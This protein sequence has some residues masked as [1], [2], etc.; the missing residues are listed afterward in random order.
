MAIHGLWAED[1]SDGKRRV[2]YAY[3]GLTAVIGVL[4]LYSA[5]VQSAH[6]RRAEAEQVQRDASNKGINDKLSQ[7]R[8]LLIPSGTKEDALQ[9]VLDDLVKGQEPRSI[10]RQ[11]SSVMS[12]ELSELPS[13]RVN[14]AVS[15]QANE[16]SEYA[17]Q[18]LSIFSSAGWNSTGVDT[19]IFPQPPTGISLMIKDKL[20][21]PPC[22]YSVVKA[23]SEN[24]IAKKPIQVLIDNGV[25]AGGL[26]ILVG[27][28]PAALLP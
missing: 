5:A 26:T 8:N 13:C 23:F 11:V 19:D 14:V 25:E 21:V 9:K 3:M 20:V 24:G 27:E 4:L 28:K 18:V 10:S 7:I 15:S 1:M 2:L 22:L 6:D 17:D 12:R 16:A